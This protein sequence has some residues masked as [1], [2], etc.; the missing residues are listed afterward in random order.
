MSESPLADA[1]VLIVEDDA[2]LRRQLQAYLERAGAEVTAVGDLASARVGLESMMFEFALVDVN[3]PDGRG[4]ELLEQ[5]RFSPNTNVVV[6]TGEGGVAGAVEA[7]RLGARDY[8]TKPFEPGEIPL[9]FARIRRSRQAQRI[10][11]HRRETETP[12][13]DEF[14][15]GSALGM[16]RELLERI[17]AADRRMQSALAPVLVQGETG[18]GKTSIARWLHTRGPRAQQPLVEVNCS[19]FPE[20]LAESELFGHERGAFTDARAARLGLFEAAHGGTLFLDELTSLSLPIQAKVLTTIEDGRIRRVGGNRPI[21]VD[22][23]IIAA[24]NVDLRELVSQGRFREDLMHRLDLFRVVI[25]PLRERRGDILPLAEALMRRAC[26]RHRLEPREISPEGRRRLESY[27]WP[28]NVRELSHELERALVFEDGP[29][30]FPTLRSALDV[31]QEA[32]QPALVGADGA[33]PRGMDW[34]NPAFR[35]PDEGFSL[36][37]ATDRLVRHA[38]EQSGG[39]VSAAARLLGVSRDVVRYRVAGR[40]RVVGMAPQERRRLGE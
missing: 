19:A 8:L 1:G 36:E 24:A 25:P 11:E 27:G 7:M 30:R 22:V 38:L 14:V 39:N 35:F 16:L 9:V 15:F 34:F 33:G 18:T 29:L 10:E 6:M 2:L 13:E 32:S 23:R 21:A 4:I 3:L 17:L 40:G 28:G 26:R 20:A 5:E 37:D 31:G 12:Q